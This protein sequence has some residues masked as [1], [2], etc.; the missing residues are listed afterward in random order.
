MLTYSAL[1]R[2]PVINEVTHADYANVAYA[3]TTH[4]RALAAVAEGLRSLNENPDLA[5]ELGAAE[6]LRARIFGKMVQGLSHA[7]VALLYD[8]GFVID[9]T[10]ETIDESGAPVLLGEPISYQALM[11]AA[12]GY[13]Y[14]AIALSNQ[15]GAADVTI[16]HDWMPLLGAGDEYTMPELREFMYSMK[17]RYR[18]NNART[19][20]ER[21]AVNWAAVLSDIQNGVHEDVL[22]DQSYTYTNW[23]G[24]NHWLF[25]VSSATWQQATYFIYG[26][27]DQSG[28]YQA[29][30]AQPLASREPNIGGN[31]AAPVV[32]VTPD[33]RFPQ[34]ATLAAQNAAPGRYLFVRSA[35]SRPD[36]GTWKWSWYANRQAANVSASA[37]PWPEIEYNEM[38]FLA[39]EGLFRTGQLQ[40]AAD[41]INVTR[42]FNGLNATNSTGL[43]TS[44]VPKLPNNTCGNLFEMLLWETRMETWFTGPYRANWFFLARGTNRLYQGTALQFPIPAEQIQVSGLGEPYTFGGVGGQSSAPTSRYNWNGES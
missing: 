6:T 21:Q 5:T 1:P 17:A 24:G 15:A 39:A 32:I 33:L 22:T 4:Y 18:A 9:E 25:Y 14:Q 7:S 37:A 34:G 38:R 26:M 16:P 11:T 3:W 35:W 43:N 23:L 12:L 20:A 40:Q 8:K 29:W 10:V 30:L 13:F 27:A 28:N 19:M 42:V 41:S 36:R 2:S 31:P 44:C